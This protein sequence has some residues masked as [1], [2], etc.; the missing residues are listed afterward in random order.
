MSA[1]KQNGRRLQFWVKDDEYEKLQKLASA[2]NRT[3]SEFLRELIYRQLEI[4]GAVSGTDIIRQHI[5]E[6]VE[7]ALTPK[8]D[9]LIK[10]LV[11]IGIMDVTMCQFNSKIIHALVPRKD[12]QGYEPIDPRNYDQMMRESKAESVY[13]LSNNKNS[14]V[15]DTVKDFKKNNSV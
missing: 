12:R 15:D 9:R 14:T 7:R 3:M 4:N 5:H 2:Q 13:Y 8:F 6:E 1:K 10:L 11:K